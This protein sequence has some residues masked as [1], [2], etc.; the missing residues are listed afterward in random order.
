MNRNKRLSISLVSNI[1]ATTV[2]LGISFFLTPYL[3]ES[4]GKEAYSFYPL[5]NN[6]SNYIRIVT[7]ALNSMASRFITIEIVQKN[8]QKAHSYFSSVFF[9]NVFLSGILLLVMIPFVIFIDL[10]L[11]VPG[12]LLTDVRVL[13]ACTFGALLL[14][15]IFSVFGIATFAKERMDLRAGREIVHSLLRAGLLIFLFVCFEPSIV[16]LGVATLLA[17]I[18]N[19]FIQLYFSRKLM[20]EY[21][22]RWSECDK[23]A[24]WTL[25]KSGVWNSINNLGSMLTMGVA[26][27]IANV[28]L[29]AA[30]GGDLSIVQTIPHLLSSIISA[31]YGVLLARIANVFAKGD[32]NATIHQVQQAQ[33]ILSGICTIPG[34]LILIFGKHF[35]NLWVPGQDAE[36]LQLLSVITLAPILIHSLMWSV[37][38]LNVTNNKLKMPALTLIGTGLISI[39]VMVILLETTNLGT[40]AITAAS[41]ICN[42]LYYLFFIPIYAAKKMEVSPWVFYSHILRSSVF[43]GIMLVLF[44][45]VTYWLGPW[46][47]NWAGFFVACCVGELVGLLL[48]LPIV[49][50]KKDTFAATSTILK[51]LKRK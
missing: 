18:A 22:V 5:A 17:G 11:N 23:G 44:L 9:S 47:G 15:L 25:V 49:C 14:N 20:P 24:V 32:K 28:M 39:V 3:L 35:F 31:V 48:Y 7:L 12:Q 10:F 42:G 43:I 34:V 33:K 19:H 4:V 13:F 6:F 26:V 40:F 30:E 51:V 46:L 16:F 1:V 45:P 21:H 29:G 8:E 36:Y 2:A 41:S 50:G 38:G 37:Y 27:L